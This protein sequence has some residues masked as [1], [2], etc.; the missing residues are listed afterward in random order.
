MAG[1]KEVEKKEPSIVGD[2]R[3]TGW[4]LECDRI[5]SLAFSRMDGKSL[6]FLMGV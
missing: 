5:R 4:G 3:N 1:A 2:D 6:A